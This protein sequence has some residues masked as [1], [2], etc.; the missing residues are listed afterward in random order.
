LRWMQEA[1]ALT[2]RDAVIQKTPLSFDVSIWEI[3]WPLL[4]GSKLV[5][6]RPGGHL[7]PLYLARLIVDENVTTLCFVPSL[8]RAFLETAPTASLRTLTRVVSCGEALST[9]LKDRVMARV[10]GAQIYNLYGPTEAAVDATAW[11]CEAGG[12]RPLAAI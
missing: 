12:D 2:D 9:E 6:A 3:F 1:Y 4:T 8:L 11:R 5:L 7:D 10:P